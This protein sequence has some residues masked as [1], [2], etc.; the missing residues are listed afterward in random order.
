[1][2]RPLPRPVSHAHEPP[3]MAPPE[4][5]EGLRSIRAACCCR[6]A[7]LVLTGP[8]VEIHSRA[9]AQ[10]CGFAC[11]T[12]VIMTG[13]LHRPSTL[14]E[15]VARIRI[16]PTRLLFLAS[17]AHINARNQGRARCENPADSTLSS[18]GYLVCSSLLLGP[19]YPPSVDRLDS[20]DSAS[21]IQATD[22]LLH[23]PVTR[24]VSILSLPTRHH[25]YTIA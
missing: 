3:P 21:G 2:C 19:S 10:P 5:A 13:G 8:H 9:D 17:G 20:W 24:P 7:R 6:Y 15:S 18:S 11:C 12:L 23:C 4:D 16:S 25:Y 14:S 1:M 22:G